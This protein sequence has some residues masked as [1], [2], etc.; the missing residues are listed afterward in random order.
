LKGI[1]C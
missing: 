1:G